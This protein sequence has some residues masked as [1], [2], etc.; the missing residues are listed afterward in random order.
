[1]SEKKLEKSE[2]RGSSSCRC[3]KVEVCASFEKFVGEFIFT[4][5]WKPFTQFSQSRIGVPSDLLMGEQA[6]RSG[7][8]S[9]HQAKA[10]EHWLHAE[11]HYKVT[12]LKTRLVEYLGEFTHQYTLT[13]SIAPVVDS[14]WP[15]LPKPPTQG[16][17]DRGKEE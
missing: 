6:A 2:S 10:L 12:G 1:M 5:E 15:D 3:Y 4:K 8:F 7:F 13:G 17:N 11:M 9:Y 14:T 16:T